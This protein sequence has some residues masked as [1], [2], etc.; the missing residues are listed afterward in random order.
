MRP[1]TTLL[2]LLLAA[3][4][5]LAAH[6]ASSAPVTAALATVVLEAHGPPPLAT[7]AHERFLQDGAAAAVPGPPPPPALWTGLTQPT[8]VSFDGRHVLIS[9]KAGYVVSF[10]SQVGWTGDAT[11]ETAPRPRAAR[12]RASAPR[13]PAHALR[14]PLRAQTAARRAGRSRGSSSTWSTPSQTT[15]ITGCSE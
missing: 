15:R 1:A 4:A 12:C 11:S 8:S 5:A 3:T 9:T 13:R 14:A 7:E 6:A 10:D 2:V